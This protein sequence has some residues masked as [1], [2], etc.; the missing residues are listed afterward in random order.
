VLDVRILVATL[1]SVLGRHGISAADSATMPYFTGNK[2]PGEP[3]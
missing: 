2:S 3:D 1:R